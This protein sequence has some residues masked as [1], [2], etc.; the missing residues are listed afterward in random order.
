MKMEKDLEVNILVVKAMV[1]SQSLII[2][3]FAILY[4]KIITLLNIHTHM[5]LPKCKEVVKSDLCFP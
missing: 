2:K 3:P 4:I 5:Y 1:R